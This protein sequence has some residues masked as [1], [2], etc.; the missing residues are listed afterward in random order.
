MESG[1]GCWDGRE[2]IAAALD[3]GMGSLGHWRMLSTRANRQ[4]T[5][6]WG[7]SQYRAFALTV[8][9]VENG[10]VVEITAFERPDLFPAFGLPSVL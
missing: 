7:D 4:P 10:A 5:R 3:A 2:A 6:R 8:L 9:R 1:G